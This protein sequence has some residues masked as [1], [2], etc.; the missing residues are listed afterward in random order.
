[1]R[2]PG[3]VRLSIDRILTQHS[4]TFETN[5][6]PTQVRGQ[7]GQIGNLKHGD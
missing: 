2:V 4:S 7:L 3:H 1:M 6:S 5:V